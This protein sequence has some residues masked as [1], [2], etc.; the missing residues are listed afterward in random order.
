VH[1]TARRDCDLSKPDE[2]R[3]KLR[4]IRPHLIINAAAYTAVDRAESDEPMA[5]AVNGEAPALIAEEA[6]RMGA[7]LVHF[8][9]DYVFD[10]AK[11]SPYE[12]S[13]RTNP[14]NV[15]GKTK[16]RGEDGIR[17]TGVP[18][19]IFRTEWL[20]ATHGKNFLLTV[21]KLASEREELRIVSDQT[22]APTWCRDIAKATMSI[23]NCL[24]PNIHTSASLAQ[25][26][27]TY[28]MTAAGVATWYDFGRAILDEAA[29]R[30]NVPSWVT[31]AAGG[32]PFVVK[33]V[34]PITAAEY[35]T[36]ACRPEYSVLSNARLKQT[37]GVELRDWR[38]A[39]RDAFRSP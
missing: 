16:L 32:K 22:G 31:D 4:E 23:L 20:Y 13:D 8:S 37:F 19:L 34:L 38:A 6:N 28:H 27:G 21:L 25:V 26:G 35:P 9:T 30:S 14:L 11:S 7:F 15:Y 24:I 5:R 10:G 29:Q 33:R 39:L 17:A 1:A 2:I 18:H 36:P 3:A 12:E